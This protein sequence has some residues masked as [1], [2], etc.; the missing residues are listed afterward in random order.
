LAP[1]PNKKKGVSFRSKTREEKKHRGSPERKCGVN[2]FQALVLLNMVGGI[3]SVRLK[4]L[5]EA[6]GEPRLVFESSAHGLLATG[7][8]TP[9]MARSILE[10]PR[11]W[12]VVREI[13]ESGRKGF[14]IL[15]L[16]DKEYPS[17]LKEIYDP[18]YV[19]YIKGDLLPA[20]ANAIGM[21]GSRGASFYG[22]SCAERFSSRLAGFGLTI[23][24]GMAR[25]IDTVSHRAA[26]NKKGRTI[27]VLGSGLNNIYPP[28]NEGL[29]EEIAKNGAV[30]TQFSLNTK[31]LAQNFPIRNRIISGL[32]RG[33]LVV[34]ASQ[35]SGALITARYALE[36]GREVFAIPGKLSSPTSFGTNDLIKQGARMV[37]EPEEILEELKANFALPPVGGQDRPRAK[38]ENFSRFN[39]KELSIIQNLNDEPKYI[40]SISEETGLNISDIMVLLMQ[41]E[42]KGVVKQL[43]GKTFVKTDFMA[44]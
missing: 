19:L 31:P 37:T 13:E 11:R 24:S 39:K 21:V 10:A 36:Q 9:L 30:L 44:N 6:L 14:K 38:T 22:L 35:K 16:F 27:A 29:F 42:L 5:V 26:L 12:D 1:F 23:V 4:K 3:G 7:A 41:L 15:T 43:P 28:E 32:C 2:N 34:E 17:I 18:P 33:V 40:D 20:D 25:G 8:L